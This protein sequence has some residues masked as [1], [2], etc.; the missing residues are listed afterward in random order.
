MHYAGLV[1]VA[2][3]SSSQSR[4][5]NNLAVFRKKKHQIPVGICP[6]GSGRSG[7]A[8]KNAEAGRTFFRDIL[9]FKSI[10]V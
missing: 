4:G 10:L 3:M 1:A 5:A 9:G 6:R 7:V 8:Y 2:V